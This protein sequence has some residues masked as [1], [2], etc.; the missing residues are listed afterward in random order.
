VRL[1][2]TV[3]G[4]LLAATL[5]V[6]VAA[7]ALPLPARTRIT[8]DSL[9]KDFATNAMVPGTAVAV[10]RGRDTLLFKAYGMANLE[11]GI[12]VSVRS[13]FRIGSVTKQFTSAA[14]MQ[15][16]QEG[17]LVIAD[18]IGHYVK[19]L[20]PTWRGVTIAQLLNHTSGIPSYTE[21]GDPWMKR[22]GEEMTGAQI[23]AL[24][25]DKPFDFPAG[26]SWK[27]D[28]TGY[29]LLGM[30]VE[31]VT[32]HTWGDE[33][34]TRFFTPLGLTQTRY[35]ENRPLIANRATG[36]S[37]N[38]KDEWLNANYLAMSQ[39]HAAGAMC[40]TIG[41]LLTWNRALHGGKVVTAASY[42]AMTSPTGAAEKQHYGFGLGI[43]QLGSHRV[44]SHTGG[45]N[46][47]LTA[48]LFVPDAQLSVTVLTNGDFAG[49]DRVAHQLARAALGVPLD[50]PPK[51]VTVPAAVLA[52]YAAKYDL[53]LD[54]L[55][56]FTVY[57][58][59]GALYGMLDG[60]SPEKLIPF[61]NHTFGAGF[62]PTV[63]IVFTMVDGKP[64]KLTLNQRGKVFDGP[65]HP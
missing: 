41:D 40:S 43:E 9:A 13:V 60:Q 23:A 55:H 35:C 54:A 46:G 1:H 10:V 52:T 24:T 64:T 56:L 45:I 17:K 31:A 49:P 51:G 58:K 36:Y 53:M 63:R 50:V 27:Y 12:P 39:P 25:A 26:T 18:S 30:L 37:R 15:L 2:S 3:A 33:F 62:D 14:V 5:P 16:V 7:Q 59:E 32:G 47:F 21:L 8:L 19:E 29:V 61:G 6:L 48:N 11:L 44:V 42:T 38:E 28:N 65:L 57:E 34:A 22:W 20:P 4:A